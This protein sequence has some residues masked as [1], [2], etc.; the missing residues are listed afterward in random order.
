MKLTEI[1]LSS[2]PPKTVAFASFAVAIF[3]AILVFIPEAVGIDDFDGGF[4]ISFFSIIVAV[5]AAI[6][7]FMYLGYAGR[8]DKILRGEGVLAHWTY[9][10]DYW[11]Q[12]TEKEYEE[13]ISEK[14]GYS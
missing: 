2:N 1:H 11:T 14:K 10:S 6:V 7:G 9:T 3:S 8:L 5:V 12:Y 4:A 13:E